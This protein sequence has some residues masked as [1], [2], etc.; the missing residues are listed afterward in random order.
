MRVYIG[1]PTSGP[2]KS[3]AVQCL[4]K[5][6]RLFN[7]KG[8]DFVLDT[9]ITNTIHFIRNTMASRALESK[10]DYLM[11]I[12]SDMV[13]DAEDILTLINSERPVTALGY[14]K[15][16]EIEE[17]CCLIESDEDG[18]PVVDDGWVELSAA[19]TGLMCIRSSVLKQ[20]MEAYSHRSYTTDNGEKRVAIF[21]YELHD[22][23][24][25][26][27]DYTFCRR[28]RDMGGKIWMLPNAHTAHVGEYEFHGNMHYFLL[29]DDHVT[30]SEYQGNEIPGWM[31]TTE[32]EWLY[33][34]AKKHKSIYEIGCWIGRSTHALCS[35]CEGTVTAIDT[36][37]GSPG[38]DFHEV[39][40]RGSLEK[41]KENMKHFDNVTAIKGDS[42]ACS[43]DAEQADM[44][45]IDGAH[46]Y[47]SVK[48]DIISWWPKAT[49]LICG[50]DYAEQWVGVRAAVDELF[51]KKIKTVGTIW[52]YEKEQ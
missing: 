16:K 23:K 28:W 15:K 44:V 24:Y 38:E 39:M 35:G 51:G 22:G 7:E 1:V 30:T 42:A 17:Y 19:G 14:R 32:L 11:F 46:D 13:F 41:F 40:G 34:Q 47:E 12:D 4:V 50:H 21:E 31:S 26:G 27:E 10:S 49:K 29:R 52:Y 36:F 25:W 45:F 43:I 9:S 6:Q 3:K 8:I 48:Q 37:Y 5:L 18:T 20:M 33:Q 2:I